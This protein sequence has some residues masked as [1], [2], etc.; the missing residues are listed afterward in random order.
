ME[1]VYA[2][3]DVHT[4]MDMKIIKVIRPWNI[5]QGNT[6]QWQNTDVTINHH[7]ENIPI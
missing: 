6:Q 7:H 2:R 5:G 4:E 3:F 1:D